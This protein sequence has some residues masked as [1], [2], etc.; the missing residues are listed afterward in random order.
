MKVS[1]PIGIFD[2]G[3]G[4]LTVAR[5][6]VDILPQENIIYFGD[7]AHF[8]YG[9]K[10]VDAVQGYVLQIIEMLLKRNCKLILIACNSAS[11]AA[12]A[13]AKDL[14]AEKALV[15][16]VIDPT[17]FFLDAH[18]SEKKVGLIATR[19]TVDSD[20]YGVRLKGKDSKIDLRSKATPLLAQVI[21]EGLYATDVVDALLKIYLQDPNLDGIDA[22]TLACTHY[23]LIKH[24]ISKFYKNRV[25]VI[26][27]ASTV[28]SHVKHLLQE[29][30]LLNQGPKTIQHFYISDYTES[31][32]RSAKV[33]FGGNIEVELIS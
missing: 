16:N 30:S 5:A 8:P 26:D 15:V 25:E 10:S 23:P 32:A 20:V 18:Y 27:T 22:L 3:I 2:S 1:D 13:L 19:L 6:I 28:A 24:K 21:E 7:T 11:A 33:F 4:G 12:Y 14:V 31:F 9:D 29:H 17:V